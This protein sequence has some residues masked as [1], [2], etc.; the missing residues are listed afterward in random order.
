MSESKQWNRREF[1]Q[2]IGYT[3]L[4]GTLDKAMPFAKEAIPAQ[5]FA[6]VAAAGEVHAFAVRGDAWQWKQSIPSRSPVSLALHPSRQI[7]YVANEID[8]Y[9]GLPRGTVEAYQFDANNAELN[10]LSRQP[11]SLSGINPRHIEVSPDGN[12][13]IVAIHGG[14]AFNVLP[15]AA[16]GSLGRVA[17][18][19]KEVGAGPHPDYQASAHPHTVA[20]D[21]SG[22]YLLATDEGCDR[23]HVFAF[24]RGRMT[25]TIQ[26]ACRP[27]SGPGHIA[28]HPSGNFLYVSNSLD[29][30]IDC[31]RWNADAAEVKHEQQV[32]T[33]A[34]AT[35]HEAQQLVISSS[36]DVLYAT[37]ADDRISSW[38][39]NP[40]TGKLSPLQQWR[41]EG[42][43]LHSLR[44]SS[45]GRRIF[46]VDRIQH[47][48]LSIYV[49][50][51]GKLGNAVM[52]A[53]VTAPITLIMSS[54]NHT[55]VVDSEDDL[56][57]V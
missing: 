6:F 43:S 5:E 7:L 48:V 24:Q 46:A 54:P 36:S 47:E 35:P 26:T 14:G 31:Y 40:V 39:I 28:V 56:D 22:Q 9:E 50:D 2:G 8:E 52:A 41:L 37:S 21:A 44:L 42:R 32:L 53:K 19:L 27:A 23:I 10:L 4:L 18:I 1:L 13:F 33:N 29:E 15:I 57:E 30:S 38:T 49:H 17:Q 45:D 34:A 3:S 16:D 20:F 51:S 11:L 25:R 55:K 12:Y